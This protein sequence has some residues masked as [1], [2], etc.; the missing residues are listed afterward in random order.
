MPAA[1]AEVDHIRISHGYSTSYLPLMVMQD[2]HLLEA[3]AA[4]MGLGKLGVSWLVIDGGNNIN[5]ALLAGA[6]DVAGIGVPGFLTL[7][8]KT[9][10]MAGHQVIGVAGVDTGGMWLNTTNPEIHSL[11]DYTA[12]DRI[13]LP[14]IKTSYA[15]VVLEMA[16]AKTFGLAQYDK[17][18]PL[19]VG[20]PHPDAMAAM[21]SGKTEIDSHFASPPFSYKELQ[22]PRI[23]R[24]F[25]SIDMIGPLSV[26]MVMAPKA[27]TDANPKVMQ[28]FLAAEGEAVSF[29]KAHR[30]EAAA[31]YL[32]VSGMKLQQDDLMQIM[33]DPEEDYGVM[34]VGIMDYATFM[35]KAGTIKAAP[36]AWTDVFIPALRDVGGK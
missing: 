16:A 33:N 36:A 10:N 12:R 34:P 27:F 13:A 14:G 5:D 25:K 17:I 21:M 26:I 29:I 15:A 23:H 28:A 7:W 20:L 4:K 24:V 6:V 2:Q 1:R 18:D 19:T 31:T 30:T 8:S 3:Q 32:R 22:D 11:R 35:A 9:Q